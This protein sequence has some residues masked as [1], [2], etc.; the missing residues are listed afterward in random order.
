MS[1]VITQPVAGGCPKCGHPAIEVPED[2]APE[3]VI[4]CPKCGHTAPHKDFF[5]NLDATG[6]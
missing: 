1:D 4:T 3:T 2:H 5:G 6:K